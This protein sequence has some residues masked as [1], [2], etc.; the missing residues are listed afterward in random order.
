M[1]IQRILGVEIIEN[2]IWFAGFE[3]EEAGIN[4]E[5]TVRL[6]TFF[7][8]PPPSEAKSPTGVKESD[9]Q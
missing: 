9:E 1:F 5:I 4:Y 8:F 2:P 3:S 7:F 6:L